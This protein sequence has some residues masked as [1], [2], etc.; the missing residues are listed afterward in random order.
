M[1]VCKATIQ[2]NRFF[3]FKNPELFRI[4]EKKIWKMAG[5]FEQNL[6]FALFYQNLIKIIFFKNSKRN[7][8]EKV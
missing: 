3:F 5:F 1:E 8:L 7:W 2:D 4:F 6:R